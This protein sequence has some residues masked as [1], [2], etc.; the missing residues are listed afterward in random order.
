[1]QVRQTYYLRIV[2]E[3]GGQFSAE[4]NNRY[5]EAKCASH[6]RSIQFYKRLLACIWSII[7]LHSSLKYAFSKVKLYRYGRHTI[8]GMSKRVEVSFRLTV[9]EIMRST[10]WVQWEGSEY[11]TMTEYS[12]TYLTKYKGQRKIY[13]FVPQSPSGFLF[14]FPNLQYLHHSVT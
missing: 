7:F 1:M 11:N 9:N 14:K 6:S 10:Y 12:L 2:Q 8:F 3:S 5:H 4:S 13:I